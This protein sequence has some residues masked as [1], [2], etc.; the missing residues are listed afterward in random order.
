MGFG[1]VARSYNLQSFQETYM[2]RRGRIRLNTLERNRKIY[3]FI[4]VSRNFTSNFSLKTDRKFIFMFQVSVQRP[5][6][7]IVI[8]LGHPQS[9]ASLAPISPSQII[10]AFLLPAYMANKCTIHKKHATL[11]VCLKYL[12]IYVY[13]SNY[14]CVSVAICVI[15]P[16]MCTCLTMCMYM[17]IFYAYKSKPVIVI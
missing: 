13:I 2:S 5:H 15:Q 3:Y 10:R 14:M 16:Y 6:Y 17:Q 4:Q 11:C 12:T 8:S 9:A 7:Q 1:Q